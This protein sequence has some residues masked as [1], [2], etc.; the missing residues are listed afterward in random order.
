MLFLR[1][2]GGVSNR[3]RRGTVDV[4]AILWVVVVDGIDIILPARRSCA[5]QIGASTGRHDRCLNIVGSRI[6]RQNVL[7]VEFVRNEMVKIPVHVWIGDEPS[8]P[9]APASPMSHFRTLMPS[10]LIFH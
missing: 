9:F 1:P 7:F 4:T 2:S 8:G 10:R 3:N 5:A 6:R